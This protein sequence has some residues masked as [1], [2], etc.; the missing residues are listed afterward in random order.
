MLKFWLLMKS[1]TFPHFNIFPRKLNIRHS[2]SNETC[3]LHLQRNLQKILKPLPLVDFYRVKYFSYVIVN[4]QT[5]GKL[6]NIANS[7]FKSFPNGGP[8]QTPT[9]AKGEAGDLGSA[10]P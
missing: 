1:Y 9:R 8:S 5:F 10:A 3:Q 6:V 4:R 7:L 2:F